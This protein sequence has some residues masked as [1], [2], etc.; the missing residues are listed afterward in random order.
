MKNNNSSNALIKNH[1]NA[2]F[3]FKSDSL[4]FERNNPEGFTGYVEKL[5]LFSAK[6]LLSLGAFLAKKNSEVE[7][8]SSV[9]PI[10][11]TN[12]IL[13]TRSSS[14]LKQLETVKT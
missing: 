13:E 14:D 8:G 9:K 6:A 3:G 10:T 1:R 11:D 4:Y 2:L 12:M 5:Q 7:P